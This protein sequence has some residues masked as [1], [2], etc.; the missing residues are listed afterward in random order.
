M[1]DFYRNQ[2]QVDNIT[3]EK[4]SIDPK[5]NELEKDT[6][7]NRYKPLK[8]ITKKLFLL[9][10]KEHINSTYMGEQFASFFDSLLSDRPESSDGQKIIDPEKLYTYYEDLQQTENKSINKEYFANL[11]ENM[12]QYFAETDLD[13]NLQI[14]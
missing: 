12:S 10:E 9:R 4:A 7:D 5:L 14:A 8:N 6:K 11:Q 13:K 2:K 3:T 1:N